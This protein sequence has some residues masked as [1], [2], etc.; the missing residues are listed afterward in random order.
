M[1]DVI[2]LRKVKSESRVRI[3]IRL[4]TFTFA[5]ITLENIW[6]HSPH[7][8]VRYIVGHESGR[9]IFLLK[10]EIV[11]AVFTSKNRII[12]I[13]R[14]MLAHF[15]FQISDKVFEFIF[16]Y[17][18]YHVMNPLSPHFQLVVDNSAF[19]TL[20]FVENFSG[21]RKTLYSKAFE[22]E[23]DSLFAEITRLRLL[24]QFL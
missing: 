7:P 16:Y 15:L 5:Q 4:V 8:A 13:I 20:C 23:P 3:R 22:R 10:N 11:I 21:R 6:I 1:G 24:C 18:M 2:A 12:I 17:N 19:C 9:I 14:N